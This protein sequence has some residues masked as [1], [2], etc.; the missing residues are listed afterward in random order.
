M[1]AQLTFRD[2]QLWL[3]GGRLN[4]S[5]PYLRRKDCEGLRTQALVLPL[6]SVLSCRDLLL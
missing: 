1:L 6:L 2:S 3:H 5:H 4:S